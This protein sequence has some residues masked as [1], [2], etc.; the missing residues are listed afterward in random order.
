[1]LTWKSVRTWYLF[2]RSSLVMELMWPCNC[3]ISFHILGTV[4]RRPCAS[5]V[6]SILWPPSG[7]IL[8]PQPPKQRSYHPVVCIL[9]PIVSN[10]Q[11]WLKFFFNHYY[12]DYDTWSMKWWNVFI[13][14]FICLFYPLLSQNQ[15][16]FVVVTKTIFRSTF[17]QCK[18]YIYIALVL[19]KKKI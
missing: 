11:M 17:W 5:A 12:Y 18:Y 9:S 2:Q 14:L 6:L 19:A 8:P 7:F 10:A 16:R 3:I 15:I 13:Y 4:G 1:M